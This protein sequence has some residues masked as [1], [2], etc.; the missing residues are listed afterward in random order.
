MG[1]LCRRKATLSRRLRRLQGLQS[2]TRKNGAAPLI[3]SRLRHVPGGGLC[4]DRTCGRWIKRP[5]PDAHR[6]SP[7]QYHAS[8]RRTIK[9]G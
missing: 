5:V 3:S 7:T 4:K 8:T 1:L 6:H 2:F 9:D